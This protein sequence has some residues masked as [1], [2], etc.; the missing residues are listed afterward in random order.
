M[1]SN[2]ELRA[3]QCATLFD[4]LQLHMKM[5]RAN[6]DKEVDYENLREL[7]TK[8]KAPMTQED[9]AWVEKQIAELYQ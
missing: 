4:L 8:A 3:Q 2:T 9:V 5:Q 7:I 1:P 6:A